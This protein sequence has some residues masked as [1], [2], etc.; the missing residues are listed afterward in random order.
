M[1]YG[2]RPH[3]WK[4]DELESMKT[5]SQYLDARLWDASRDPIPHRQFNIS[6]KQACRIWPSSPRQSPEA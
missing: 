4:F 5:L 1:S 2:T 6:A 3:N